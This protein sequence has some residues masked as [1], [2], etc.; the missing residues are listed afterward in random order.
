MTRNKTKVIKRPK[1]IKRRFIYCIKYLIRLHCAVKYVPVFLGEG[2]MTT[3]NR[4]SYNTIVRNAY[5][6]NIFVN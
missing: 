2:L 6:C 5:N 1:V 3:I 4:V